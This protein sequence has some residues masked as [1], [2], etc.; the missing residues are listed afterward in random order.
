MTIAL[1]VVLELEKFGTEYLN[2]DYNVM[3]IINSQWAENQLEITFIDKLVRHEIDM[4]ETNFYIKTTEYLLNTIV[5][6][7]EKIA[8]MDEFVT[9]MKI[10]DFMINSHIE[11]KMFDVKIKKVRVID[12]CD[13]ELI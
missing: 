13:M 7:D 3:N 10:N 11:N 12:Y 2:L 6:I 5:M 9:K 8:D 1:H 4:D